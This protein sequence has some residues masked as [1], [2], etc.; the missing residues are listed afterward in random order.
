M[1]SARLS[2]AVAVAA[3]AVVLIAI[4]S[5]PIAEASKHH[6]KHH[7]RTLAH[8]KVHRLK[9]RLEANAGKVSYAW[10]TSSWGDCSATCG[11]GHKTRSVVCF[12]SDGNIADDSACDD[13]SRPEN[14]K[15][16]VE[17][18]CGAWTYGD[19]SDCSATCGSSARTRKVKCIDHSG[20]T[21][22]DSSCDSAE[23][24][25]A[26]EACTLDDCEV[27]SWVVG[28]WSDCSATCGDG[29]KTRQYTCT[30]EKGKVST[31]PA[32]DCG[33][34]Q[35]FV[36]SRPCNSGVCKKNQGAEVDTA[37]GEVIAASGSQGVGSTTVSASAIQAYLSASG[38]HNN[39]ASAT[40]T[41]AVAF[42]VTLV[43]AV[44]VL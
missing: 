30:D 40:A 43:A 32:S 3:A 39:T 22:D 1:A 35:Q 9:D 42:A 18:A 4:A 19:W 2:V 20:S 5:L 16:C 29:T 38:R 27:W 11:N 15:D 6:N 41:P 13:S 23:K 7:A 31:Q 36:T 8:E 14:S 33:N 25:S 28:D 37:G 24:P 17:G 21:I 10:Q 34:N 44:L 26:V 12:D